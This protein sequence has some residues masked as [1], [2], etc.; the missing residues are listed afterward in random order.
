MACFLKPFVVPERYRAEPD[1]RPEGQRFCSDPACE[2]L[3]QQEILA[4]WDGCCGV[5]HPIC[6]RLLG[7]GM[8][9][10]LRIN[11]GPHMLRTLQRMGPVFGAS[12]RDVVEFNI[13]LWHHKREGQY[14]GY[15]QALADHYVANGT[16][17][18]TL[19]WRDNSP[20][21]FDIENGEFP[22]P[23]D[24]PAL[25]YNVGKGGRCVPMQNVTLQPDGTI[26]GGNEHVARGGWRNIMTD[27]IMGAAGIPIHRTWNN[28]V[29]MHG[30]HT[31]GECTHW[32]SPGAYSVWVWSL[33]R[34]LLK[35]GLAQ[36]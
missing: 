30:G 33:W 21:H 17:G 35:H 34:T 25:L 2:Q 24:A 5:E 31:R 29:M 9:C 18:P 15:V 23:D 19:I 12:Q 36:P 8:V 7:G 16:S 32:C 27:P 10:H 14:G 1:W 26:T 13:G 11:Q 28:T 3:I 20:Q 22:H 4:D 6:T